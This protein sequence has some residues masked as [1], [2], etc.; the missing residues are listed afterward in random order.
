MTNDC[1]RSDTALVD[2]DEDELGYKE[3]AAD[4]AELIEQDVP[5]NGFVI[6]VNG[7]WGSGKST[8]LN[9]LETELS[10]SH[11]NTTIV[12]FILTDIDT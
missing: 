10:A 1:L 6:S 2:P 7:P 4:L 3:F 5:Q 12:R 11:K 8:V 9:F